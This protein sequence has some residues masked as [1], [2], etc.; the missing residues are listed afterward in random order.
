MSLRSTTIDR[1]ETSCFTSN[2]DFVCTRKD[3][4]GSRTLEITPSSVQDGLRSP[5]S[6]ILSRNMWCADDSGANIEPRVT[7]VY[8]EGVDTMILGCSTYILQLIHSSH[9]NCSLQV[10][11]EFAELR[12]PIGPKGV[13]SQ[14]APKSVKSR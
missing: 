10:T 11:E 8:L 13:Y 5:P 9:K 6:Q 4:S 7:A 1:S 2:G 14:P 12:W 3:K